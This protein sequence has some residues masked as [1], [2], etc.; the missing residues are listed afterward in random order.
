MKR[1]FLAFC[2]VLAL[3]TGCQNNVSGTDENPSVNPTQ[4]TPSQT[5]LKQKIAA[6]ENGSVIDLGSE[7]LKIEEADSYTISKPLT[8]K[9]GNIKNATF[10]VES[11][12]VTLENITDIKSIIVDEKVGDGDF[13]LKNCQEVGEV[14]V[15]G[16]GQNSV[17]IEK[18]AVVKLVV[19]KKDV[20]IA[21]SGDNSTKIE[22]TLILEDCKLDSNNENASFGDVIVS[23]IVKNLELAGKT[24]IEKIV[25]TVQNSE[26][27]NITI[28]V[29]V[30][31]TIVA[32]DSTVKEAISSDSTFDKTKINEAEL[33]AEEKADIEE[34]KKVKEEAEIKKLNFYIWRRN[35]ETNIY[36]TTKQNSNGKYV[37]KI[38]EISIEKTNSEVIITNK[39][40]QSTADKVWNYFIQPTSLPN[41]KAGENY[42][43]SFDLKA[44]KDSYI[45]MQAKDEKR[46]ANGNSSNY[47]VTT[48]WKTFSITT[49]TAKLDYMDTS[50]YIALGTVSKIYIKNYKFEKISD[51]EYFGKQIF[52]GDKNDSLDLISVKEISENNINISYK[53][54]CSGKSG[55]DITLI[56]DP[57]CDGKVYKFTFDII[58]DTNLSNGDFDIW[59][60]SGNSENNISGSPHFEFS[61]NS[62]K[63]I[64]VYFVGHQQQDE[65]A[66]YPYIWFASKK[67][68]NL[69]IKN[70][71]L[72][73]TT[74]DSIQKEN[75]E[76]HFYFA[77]TIKTI[78]ET[79]GEWQVLALDKEILLPSNTEVN[80]QI[81]FCDY[82]NWGSSK[83]S[84]TSFR[85]LE[86]DTG[87][88]INLEQKT[89][90]DDIFFSNKTNSPVW[91]KFSLN[92]KNEVV[93]TQVEGYGF[94]K[95]NKT[96]YLV[97]P[98]S[99]ENYDDYVSSVIDW[100]SSDKFQKGNW[101]KVTFN[102]ESSK[103]RNPSLDEYAEIIS[104]SYNNSNESDTYVL[105]KNR[106]KISEEPQSIEQVFQ[107]KENCDSLILEVCGK[108][109]IIKFTDWNIEQTSEPAKE[110]SWYYYDI[111]KSDL[112]SA[113]TFNIIF[114]NGNGIQTTNITDLDVNTNIYC[115]DFWKSEEQT[116][117]DGTT[118]TVYK[119]EI[120]SREDN[121]TQ[122]PAEDCIRIY[123]YS[124]LLETEH[125]YLHYWSTNTSTEV[126]FSTTWPGEK[127]KIVE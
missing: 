94:D 57:I 31:V 105:S 41:V 49:G 25:S 17:H 97:I 36:E 72:A 67:A 114:N 103:K 33:S 104:I 100:I 84:T 79:E 22:K 71:K 19:Q 99:E 107:I 53:K 73:E 46:S 13:N 34:E 123:F 80:G 32:A 63:T 9:N 69:T 3:F 12:N 93:A 56:N 86:K 48:E 65:D 75:S 120:S 61:A 29:N 42:E 30:D 40:S 68:C 125:A 112:G 51:K 54:N 122:P 55:V 6:A 62:S 52:L 66:F 35:W 82:N 23:E 26:K 4:E 27:P 2:V 58:S 11:T 89:G 111:K 115:Y 98:P 113:E 37:E 85:T 106:I 8:I 78:G 1:L 64:T 121:P 15:N 45:V 24:K 77:G 14:Y 91:V 74:F 59:A 28:V 126:V 109:A 96:V 44:D 87:K 116:D 76:L 101:Y 50:V 95:N 18:T 108:N 119:S 102:I 39:N 124:Q 83:N 16:G 88:F 90:S 110:E 118:Y 43:I 38:D 20:R 7:E 21:L 60:N 70:F 5:T 81:L 127:M 10:V 92:E 47:N 117:S